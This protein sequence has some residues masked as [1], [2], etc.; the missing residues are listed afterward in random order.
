[1][2]LGDGIPCRVHSFYAGMT[3]RQAIQRLTRKVTEL[4]TPNL[5]VEH[6][7]RMDPN[8]PSAIDAFYSHTSKNGKTS[9]VRPR[10]IAIYRIGRIRYCKLRNRIAHSLTRINNRVRQTQA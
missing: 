6:F 7:Q 8:P 10:A 5:V 9:D 1:M 2:E 3:L 4:Q